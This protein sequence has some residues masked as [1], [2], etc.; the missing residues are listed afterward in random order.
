MPRQF[1]FDRFI[2]ALMEPEGSAGSGRLRETLG[3]RQVTAKPARPRG[4]GRREAAA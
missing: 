1:L 3:K 4:P 2:E